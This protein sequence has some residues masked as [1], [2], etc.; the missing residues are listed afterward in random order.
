MCLEQEKNNEGK[1]L[2][3]KHYVSKQQTA[4]NLTD[5]KIK[6]YFTKNIFLNYLVY[7]HV[8]PPHCVQMSGKI[9]DLL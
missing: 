2:E 7:L 9:I 8:P 6:Q 4:W 3:R 1:L 5:Y